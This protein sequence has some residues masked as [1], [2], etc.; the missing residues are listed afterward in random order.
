MAGDI[1][2]HK[3]TKGRNQNW[4]REEAILLL[5]YYLQLR[6]D[7]KIPGRQSSALQE[8]SDTLNR[9]GEVREATRMTSFRNVDGV[10][11][12]LYVFTS[13]DRPRAKWKKAAKAG[14]VFRKVWN[15]LGGNPDEVKAMADAIRAHID[16][17]ELTEKPLL[18]DIAPDDIDLRELSDIEGR[19]L[20]VSHLRRERKPRLVEKLKAT[21]FDEKGFLDCEVCAFDFERTYGRRGHRYMEAH[22][23]KP[24]SSLKPEGERTCLADYTLLCAN[25]HRMI[26]RYSPWWSV[27]ELRANLN[28]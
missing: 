15:D 3:K 9:L 7:K 23:K 6:S 8:L 4:S 25:C 1:A 13:L 5:D 10:I 16:H 20:E 26:H 19:V 27:E 11:R 28:S 18:A 2:T 17:A 21:R 22:H 12:R 24:L 14:K